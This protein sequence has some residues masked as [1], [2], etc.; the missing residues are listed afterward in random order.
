MTTPN[1]YS[2]EE[3]QYRTLSKKAKGKFGGGGSQF[4]NALPSS[5]FTPRTSALT[6]SLYHVTSPDDQLKWSLATSY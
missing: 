6:I 2:V 5:L 4:R 3:N 1:D